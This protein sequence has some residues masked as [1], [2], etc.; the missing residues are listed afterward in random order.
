MT[1]PY[2][3]LPGLNRRQLLRA[4]VVGGSA[5]AGL[6]SSRV[7][8]NAAHQPYEGPLLVTLQLNGGVD[9]TQLCDPKVNVK[10]EPKINHWADTADPGQAGNLRY[11][12][13]ANNAAFFERFGRD[14]LVINGVDSQTNSHETGKLY[15]WTGSNAEGRP[16]LSA[17]F[18]A[19]QSPKQ[20][21]AYSVF[22]GFS[23]TA[24]L[25]G[26]NR[27]D[28]LSNMG[29]LIRPN[30]DPW[31]G[32]VKRAETDVIRSQQLVQDGVQSLLLQPN[33]SVRQRQSAL[34]F[35]EARDG[36]EGL[37]RLAELV[38]AEEDIQRREDFTA[39][40]MTFSSNL[41]QQMQGSLLVFKSGLGSAADLALDGFDS[42]DIHDPVSET[43]LAHFA[44]AVHFFWDYAQELGLA[45]RILLVIGSDFGRTN[46]YNDGNGK[47]HWPIG[48]YMVMERD[49]P[50]GDRMVGLTDELHFAKPINVETLQEDAKGLVMTPAHVHK[51]LRKY[52]G[53]E[54]FAADLGLDV[55]VET[56]PIFDPFLSS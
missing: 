8:S 27:F 14:M 18:A 28:G 32:G 2:K 23:R 22:D 16:S 38:P 30:V 24:G 3:S 53:L 39:G 20:P 49:A 33:L 43:L 36:R 47:D 35:V 19:V 44:D 40:G 15:N 51:A 29:A 31:S 9:V 52:L 50:W 17:L 56:P 21:L 13:V 26:Y 6:L 25:I 7:W 42:H 34:R 4:A 45:D 54:T 10:G 48:S 41:K 5:A 11:A 12:P 37:Q 46:F 1:S 55:S